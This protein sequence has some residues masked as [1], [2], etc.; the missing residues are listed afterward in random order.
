M[1][2]IQD[3]CT[4]IKVYTWTTMK[5]LADKLENEQF[6]NLRNGESRKKNNPKYSETGRRVSTNSL[7]SC[8]LS[9]QLR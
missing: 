3:G 5:S 1:R 2:E 9:R 7:F 8:V 6:A 4:V